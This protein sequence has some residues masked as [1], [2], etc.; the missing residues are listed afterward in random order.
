MQDVRDDILVYAVLDNS[1]YN[2]LAYT[3][4]VIQARRRNIDGVYDIV[5]DLMVMSKTA[6]DSLFASLRS[7]LEKLQ[8]RVLLSPLPRYIVRVGDA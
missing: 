6:Q 4:G 2:V 1:M 3:G 8:K 5:G 7:L